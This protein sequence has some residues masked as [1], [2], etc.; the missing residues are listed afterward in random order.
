MHQVVD[1]KGEVLLDHI[2]F[3]M[4]YYLATGSCEVWQWFL[5]DIFF[6]CL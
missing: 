5:T 3:Q 2:L 1:M 6:S 4:Y